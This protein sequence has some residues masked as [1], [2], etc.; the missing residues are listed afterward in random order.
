MRP[1]A[2]KVAHSTQ[3]VSLFLPPPQ[4][5]STSSREPHVDKLRFPI[6]LWASMC[7]QMPHNELLH[8]LARAVNGRTLPRNGIVVNLIFRWGDKVTHGGT[9]IVLFPQCIFLHEWGRQDISSETNYLLTCHFLCCDGTDISRVCKL[10]TKWL[11]DSSCMS[12]RRSVL[13]VKLVSHWKSFH[14]SWYL[15]IFLNLSR[16]FRFY[17]SLTRITGTLHED[18]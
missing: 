8:V 3:Q 6:L 11:L 13:M 7:F 10:A 1:A 15:S 2:Y 12:V 4:P 16:E 14:G 5:F 17:W 9:V 18:Q